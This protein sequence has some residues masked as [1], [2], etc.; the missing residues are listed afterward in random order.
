MKEVFSRPGFSLIISRRVCALYGDR[1]K[2]R[3][4]EPIVPNEVG[5][6]ACKRYYACI[7]DFNCPALSVDED[8]QARISR[9]ICD[10]CMVC[11]KLC[12]ATA[13]KTTGEA[14]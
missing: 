9:D 5:K 11:A 14:R 8:G 6:E 10:G 3:K 12:P 4:G 1:I 13:I 2:R 7:R